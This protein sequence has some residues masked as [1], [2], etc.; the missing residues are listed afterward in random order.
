MST[1]V[2][3][4]LDYEFENR[5][6]LEFAFRSAHRSDQDGTSYDGNRGLAYYGTLAMQIAETHDSIVEKKNTLRQLTTLP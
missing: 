2:Q 5:Q 6:L 4:A 1:L 3:T